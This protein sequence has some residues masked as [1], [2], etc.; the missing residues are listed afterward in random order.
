MNQP[1]K[2]AVPTQYTH[3]RTHGF[4]IVELMI[5]LTLGLFVIGGVISIFIATQQANRATEGL[6]RAQETQR[7]AFEFMAR[8]IREAGGNYC[9]RNLQSTTNIAAPRWWQDARTQLRGLEADVLMPLPLAPDGPPAAGTGSRI[10]GTDAI[11]ITS[12]SLSE[13]YSIATSIPEPAVAPA[14]TLNRAL[15]ANDFA[16]GSL[17]VACDYTQ[18][19]LFPVSVRNPAG[20]VSYAYVAARPLI[21]PRNTAHSFMLAPDK[22]PAT[23]TPFNAETWYIG[24][25]SN[26]DPTYP[27]Q[28]S[29]YRQR[30]A[31]AALVV[32]EIAENV[33]DMQITY[34]RF[35]NAAAG[36]VPAAP[37]WTAADWASVI[38]VRITLTIET[39][40][41]VNE[42]VDDTLNADSNNDGVLENVAT[43]DINEHLTA[44]RTL[45]QT[46]IIRNRAE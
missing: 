8:S 10:A 15:N 14:F 39:P 45:T 33:T 12:A 11:Q 5:G 4:S 6:S 32:E 24:V 46:I 31:G 25:S 13:P 37:A 43:A 26:P 28:R 35:G 2:T 36:Y 9:G 21:L 30:L 41:G 27:V 29:L 23:L 17:A 1:I 3:G 38:A 22:I 44:R 19:S 16:V 40:I 20:V 42:R 18:T 7:T 34:L